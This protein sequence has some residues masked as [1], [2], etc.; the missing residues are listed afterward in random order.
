MARVRRASGRESLWV[1]MGREVCDEYPGRRRMK[2]HD[3]DDETA[4]DGDS[5]S[6]SYRMK[7]TRMKGVW[8]GVNASTSRSSGL[9]QQVKGT[10]GTG[11]TMR[12]ETATA[13]TSTSSEYD[14]GAGNGEG[15]KE[16]EG[17]I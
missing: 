9:G 8:P 15:E 16:G 3:K 1:D 14:D 11:G 7:E 12:T 5:G 10:T 13:I 6:R 17:W 4:G 2:T